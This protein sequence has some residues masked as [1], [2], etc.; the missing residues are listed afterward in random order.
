MLAFASKTPL[1]S[2]FCDNRRRKSSDSMGRSSPAGQKKPCNVWIGVQALC[3]SCN[4]G[5]KYLLNKSTSSYIQKTPALEVFVS[6]FIRKF[7]EPRK[8][9]ITHGLQKRFIFSSLTRAEIF[10]PKS[11]K[12]T[13]QKLPCKKL[14]ICISSDRNS[15]RNM[16]GRAYLDSRRTSET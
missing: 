3:T 6:D 7:Q 15:K 12:K 14:P 1:A 16:A 9:F 2:L 13:F 5:E 8:S 4:V 11:R 10:M